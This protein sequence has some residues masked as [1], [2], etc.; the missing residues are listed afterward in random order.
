MLNSLAFKCDFFRYCILLKEGGIYSDLRQNI[1][2]KIDLS[3]NKYDFVYVIE[4]HVEWQSYLKIEYP[5]VQNCFI[6]VV[7]NHPYIKCCLDLVCQNVL[8]R[9]YGLCDIDITGPIVFGCAIN[10]VKKTWSHMNEKREKKYYFNKYKNK[11]V[12]SEHDISE[13]NDNHNYIINHKYDGVSNILCNER[14]YAISWNY[15]E[16]FVTNYIYNKINHHIREIKT[17]Y[18]KYTF[19]KF[20]TSKEEYIISLNSFILI[21]DNT[22]SPNLYMNNFILNHKYCK[23][24][25][26]FKI[27]NSRLV[28]LC[29]D[30]NFIEDINT[31]NDLHMFISKFAYKISNIIIWND[32]PSHKIANNDL[33]IILDYL[34]QIKQTYNSGFDFYESFYLYSINVQKNILN[35]SD[36]FEGNSI[37][38]KKFINNVKPYMIYFPQFHN[39][40][41]NNLNYY[42]GFTDANNLQLLINSNSDVNKF[43]YETTITPLVCE[44]ISDY[45][46][47]NRNII[48]KQ[49]DIICNYNIEGFAIYYYWFSIN[50]ITNEN[51][52][53][54][55]PIDL[56]FSSDLKNKNIFFIWA[57]E[58]WTKSEALSGNKEH[59]ILNNYKEEDLLNNINNLIYYFKKNNYLKINNKPVLFIH[60]PWLIPNESLNSL[61]EIFNNTCILNGFDGIEL[62]VNSMFQKYTN[63]KNYSHNLNY[64][65]N[66][67]NDECKYYDTIFLR[68]IVNYEEYIEKH[69]KN[70]EIN[71]YFTDF[72]NRARL[73][74]PNK[75]EL[76]TSIVN[77]TDYNKQKFLYKIMNTYKNKTKYIDQILLINGFNE[78]GEQM[79]FEP[80]KE[81]KYYNLNL[82][83]KYLVDEKKETNILILSPGKTGS[84][85]LNDTLQSIKHYDIYRF[86]SNENYIQFSHQIDQSLSTD[87]YD[88]IDTKKFKYIINVHRNYTDR[89]MSAL[90]QC[91]DN[92]NEQNKIY[93]IPSLTEN[94]DIEKL[95]TFFINNLLY[96]D[97]ETYEPITELLAH[98]DIVV[99]NNFFDF[100]KKYGIINI[101]EHTKLL[102]LRFK[103][104]KYW[105]EILSKVMD[106][107]ISLTSS[108]LSE[109]KP[110]YD[111]Y[112]KLKKLILNSNID[113]NILSSYID[114]RSHALYKF[115]YKNDDDLL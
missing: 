72:C 14:P 108:N 9:Y 36:S 27:I 105:D 12:I 6:A 22:Y 45:D 16:T 89:K 17:P 68:N 8:N 43:K 20:I 56:I 64:K 90:F 7:P 15:S 62:V 10:E 93:N 110:N 94:I 101:N 77:N 28:I 61:N 99:P 30:N 19:N 115:C 44:K 84:N 60:H 39:I 42:D 102:I 4:K 96:S 76:S 46:L 47:T 26:T 104:I 109:K 75:L 107:K 49:I 65:F 69:V 32:I 53:M 29:N 54:K 31:V 85:T 2:E 25:I 88:F 34:K 11:Y 52:I 50:T 51:M 80:S 41:E 13:I 40:T 97:F 21:I 38:D 67:N 70:D 79:A 37:A 74:K 1:I 33:E 59:S 111:T 63:F 3:E 86:H 18:N 81:Y 87:L 92:P 55:K 82:F 100:E 58:C 103:D 71:V 95:K 35:I 23:T 48:E 83:K 57:N 114:E 91:L 98:Y 106:Y 5:S 24:F 73:F 112:K 78:W 113:K 66:R